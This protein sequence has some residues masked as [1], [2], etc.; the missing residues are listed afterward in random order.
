MK[1]TWGLLTAIIVLTFVL[2]SCNNARLP[3]AAEL[4]SQGTFRNNA[5]PVT[6]AQVALLAQ[7]I[8]AADVNAALD[9]L[10]AAPSPNTSQAATLARLRVYKANSGQNYLTVKNLAIRIPNAATS[11]P[12]SPATNYPTNYCATNNFPT[13]WNWTPPTFADQPRAATGGTPLI[14]HYRN[15]Q[16]LATYTKFGQGS[17]GR[18]DMQDDPDPE[19][20]AFHRNG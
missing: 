14:K 18:P 7:R 3:E 15:G 8:T 16:L 4:S 10:G 2:V 11:Q 1:T 5:V 17:F 6:D 19:A 12:L 20:G 9:A 13:Q